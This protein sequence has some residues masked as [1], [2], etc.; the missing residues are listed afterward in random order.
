MPRGLPGDMIVFATI[1]DQRP[2]RPGTRAG[3]AVAVDFQIVAFLGIAAALLLGI[4]VWPDVSCQNFLNDFITDHLGAANYVFRLYTNNIVPGTGT[5]LADLTEA[6]WAGYAS[7]AGNT[8]TWPAATLAAHV[9]Q[10]TGSNIVFNNTSVSGQIAY[11]VYVTNVA[12]TKLYFV[13]RDVNAPVT[14]PAS[15]S[16]VYTP[17]QQYKSIN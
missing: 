3:A 5:V 12:N 14:L 2:G 17:N 6:T 9:A 10:S 16:Y 11:G 4:V 15:G 13:E 8:I 1:R 7:V